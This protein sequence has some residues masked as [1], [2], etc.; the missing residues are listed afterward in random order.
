MRFQHDINVIH[1][2][3]HRKLDTNII[4]CTCVHA[5]LN[6]QIF[7]HGQQEASY[8]VSGPSSVHRVEQS[9]RAFAT[10][11]TPTKQTLRGGQW[12]ML[13]TKL[14]IEP[15]Q[16]GQIGI[17]CLSDS[18]SKHHLLRSIHC[19]FSAVTEITRLQRFTSNSRPYFG[20]LIQ[21]HIVMSVKITCESRTVQCSKCAMETTAK[22]EM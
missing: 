16:A 9:G 8:S 20:K 4:A 10:D 14:S 3:Y 11:I 15:P 7:N 2:R 6:Q 12:T 21:A 18:R 17:C 5:E 1:N 22:S 13:Q 19:N